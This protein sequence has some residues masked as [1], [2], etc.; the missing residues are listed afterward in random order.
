MSITIFLTVWRCFLVRF[1]KMS[2]SG[3]CSILKATAKWWFSST[4]SSLY[5]RASSELVLMRYWFVRPGWSASWMVD[6]NR[7]AKISRGVNTDWKI[8][9]LE[10]ERDNQIKY[11]CGYTG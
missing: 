11:Q 4:D 5:M 2:H 8:F 10:V 7:A 3:Y 9:A 1:T 6:A